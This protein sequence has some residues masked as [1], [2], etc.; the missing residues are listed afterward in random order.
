M[1]IWLMSLVSHMLFIKSIIFNPDPSN[2][3]KLLNPLQKA[4]VGIKENRIIM[5]GAITWVEKKMIIS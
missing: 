2:L 1:T 4:K 3:V 5:D